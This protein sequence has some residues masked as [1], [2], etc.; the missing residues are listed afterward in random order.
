MDGREAPL[1]TE[2]RY[3][4]VE[5]ALADLLG[6]SKKG[7]GAFRARLRHLRN[8]GLPELPDALK[9]PGSGRQIVYT[10]EH[11]LEL[12]VALELESVGVVPRLV[13]MQAPSIVRMFRYGE[14]DGDSYVIL[15]PSAG[16][17][18]YKLASGPAGLAKALGDAP[19]AIAVINVSKCAARLD[20]AL[21]RVLAE[22]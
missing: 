11:A 4:H 18:I 16:R 21:V 8:I 5:A 14:R 12:L 20:I 15:S 7:L 9:R 19:R 22:E 10:R 6:I 17:P 3:G 13:R 2:F 1:A